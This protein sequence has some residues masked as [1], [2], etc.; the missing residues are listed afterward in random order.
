MEIKIIRTD[1]KQEAHTLKPNRATIGACAKLIGADT[2]DVVSLRDGRVMLVDDTGM[3]D[4]KP[5][6]REATKLYHDVRNTTNTIY[7]DVIIAT[8]ADFGLD[9]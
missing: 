3:I 6:N 1:G 4:G 8:D 7:G 5:I 9:G 2:L